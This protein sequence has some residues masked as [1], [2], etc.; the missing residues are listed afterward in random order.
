MKLPPAINVL[1]PGQWIKNALVLAGFFFAMADRFQNATMSASLVRT[2]VATACF[3]LLSGSIYVFNDLH[4]VEA[5]R[6]HPEKKKRPI[7][8]GRLSPR[9]AL[10]EG[11]ALSALSLAGCFLVSPWLGLCAALYLL[12]QVLY[13]RWLKTIVVV[14]V[15][16]LAAGFVLRVWAGTLAADVHLSPWILVCTFAAAWF[17][18]NGKRRSEKATLGESASRHRPVLARYSLQGLSFTCM[19]GAT[20]TFACYLAWTLV[21]EVTSK[22]GTRLLWVTSIP[23][24]LGLFRYLWLVLMRDEGGRPERLFMRDALLIL[25][26]VAYLATTIWVLFR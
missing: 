18:G 3:C 24:F 6:I 9:T 23:V 13:T 10:V 5:D 4:D 22:F 8:S 26:A 7:A 14:D 19:V 15:L 20:V 2:L 25:S 11:F 21:P 12:L 16:A 17:L 1:R